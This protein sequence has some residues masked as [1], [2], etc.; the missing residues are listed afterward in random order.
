MLECVDKRLV[1]G[2]TGEGIDDFS[3]YDVRELVLLLGEA[4]DVLSKGLVR[5]LPA[6]TQLPRVTRSSVCTLEM[7]NEG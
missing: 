4:L 7:P 6:I 1:G 2:A 5:P 3:V